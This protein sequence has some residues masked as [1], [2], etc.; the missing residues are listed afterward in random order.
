MKKLNKFMLF[1]AAAVFTLTACEE[2]VERKPSPED[3]QGAVAAELVRAGAKQI[4]LGHL[5]K[6]NN[7]PELALK[8]CELALYDAGLTPQQDARIVV[9][10]RD[11]NI[12]MFS[13]SAELQM[14]RQ[15]Y[16]I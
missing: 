12:G 8:C 4:I 1:L 5:S 15:E 3:P 6:E 11:G 14:H 13:I 9:A 2:N 7:Y 10:S 16:Y